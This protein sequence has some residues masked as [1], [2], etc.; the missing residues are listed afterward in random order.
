ME[1]GEWL[2]VVLSLSLSGTLLFLVLLALKRL[3]GKRVS[4]CW[5]YYILLAVALRFLVPF[6]PDTTIVGFLFETAQNAV[7]NASVN[8]TA[9]TGMG[10]TGI[11]VEHNDVMNADSPVIVGSQPVS[12]GNPAFSDSGTV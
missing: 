6:S 9:N 8:A 12:N 11:G 4:K 5:Q 7:K 10:R 2:K 3:Y 1:M